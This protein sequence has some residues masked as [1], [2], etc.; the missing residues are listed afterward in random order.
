M[1]V[2]IEDMKISHAKVLITLLFY[3]DTTFPETI[4]IIRT[5]ERPSKWKKEKWKDGVDSFHIPQSVCYRQN[6]GYG[7]YCN[8]SCTTDHSRYLCRCSDENSTVTYFKDRWRCLE[9]KEVRKQLG[10][11]FEIVLECKTVYR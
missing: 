10:K 4:E 5:L 9:N 1:Y 8:T 3:I 6:S 11:Y 2:C 7:N